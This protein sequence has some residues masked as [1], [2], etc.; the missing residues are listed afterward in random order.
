ML[1][2]EETRILKIW[3]LFSKGFPSVKGTHCKAANYSEG[4]G[5][6]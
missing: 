1:V 3:P 4:G 6:K 2:F 5:G